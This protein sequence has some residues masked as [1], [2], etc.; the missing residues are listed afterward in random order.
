MIKKPSH[1]RRAFLKSSALLTGAFALPSIR[2]PFATLFG[3]AAAQKYFG[4]AAA[5]S[6]I[7]L[8]AEGATSTQDFTGDMPMRIHEV[9]WNKVN[10]LKE[11]GGLPKPTEFVDVVVV[12]GGMSGLLS[13]YQ[14]RNHKPILLEANLRFGGNS[15]GEKMGSTEFCTGAAYIAP[16][17]AGGEI[18][19][20][21]KDLGLFEKG[22]TEEGLDSTVEFQ[23]HLM[24]PFWSGAT[25]PAHADQ[26]KKVA[27]ELIRIRDH[28]YPEIPATKN[29]L[30]SRTALNALD[31]QTFEEW[32]Q[33]KFGDK[34][35]PHI[36][37]YF[38]LYAWSSLGGSINELSAAQMLN[39]ICS[40]LNGTFALPGGNAA[41]ARAL[42]D[43][44]KLASGD[45]RVRAGSIVFDIRKVNDEV[46]ITYEDPQQKLHAIRAKTC[47]VA[48]PKFA[49]PIVIEDLPD[50]QDSWMR[51]LNYRAY[52]VANVMLKKPLKSPCFE[53]FRLQGSMPQPPEAFEEETRVFTDVCFGSWAA[54]DHADRSTLTIFKTFPYDGA[55]STLLRPGAHAKYKEQIE[56]ELPAM[57]K[58]LGIDASDVA[59]MRMSRYGH[60]LPLAKAG[61]I[62]K[63]GPEFLSTPYKE[64]VFFANQD[65]WASPCFE[66][67]AS[68]AFQ[69]AESA[70]RYL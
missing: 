47:I 29:S 19:T 55:R 14:L 26:F 6:P 51:R 59:G 30:I 57:L 67:C 40:D 41:I 20:L 27:A 35:H 52:L 32:L 38:Q 13:A 64:S 33:T 69:A 4:D 42:L 49:V 66:V 68:T 44:V 45:E 24:H 70:K 53:L 17:E 65:N 8:L 21:L 2:G 58:A 12:G 46:V 48:L 63:G 39:F 43:Q 37:E 54:S 9:L 10:Y 23:G 1:D 34:I 7:E 25:D 36:L 50:D 11:V 22:R 15:R 60:A 28:A 3:P 16:P 62:A 31:K 61:V 18:E 5:D 56:A